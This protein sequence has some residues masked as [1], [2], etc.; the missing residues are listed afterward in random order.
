MPY[1]I[2]MIL[3]TGALPAVGATTYALYRTNMRNLDKAVLPARTE[4]LFAQLALFACEGEVDPDARELF[5][6][7]EPQGVLGLLELIVAAGTAEVRYAVGQLRLKDAESQVRAVCGE[8]GGR[9][10]LATLHLLPAFDRRIER[11]R[12]RTSPLAARA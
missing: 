11:L 8:V 1:D 4:M 5:D 12:R 2:G 10:A 9:D 6:G 7:L 3:V